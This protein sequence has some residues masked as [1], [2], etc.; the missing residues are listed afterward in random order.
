MANDERT[1][2]TGKAARRTGRILTGLVVLFLAWDGVMKRVQPEVVVKGTV[3]LGYPP[4]VI[5]PL[6]LILLACVIL[7]AIPR[8]A[9]L[10]AILLTGYL[11]GAVATNLRVGNPLFLYVLFPVYVGALAWLG[12]YLRDA[13]L[14]RVL[15]DG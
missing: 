10:G 14:R 9:V 5:L 6:G 11:G 13:R 7:Y 2:G 12:L 1:T 8:T 4:D 3:D 15:V